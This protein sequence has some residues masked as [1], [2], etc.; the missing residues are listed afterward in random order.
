MEKYYYIASAFSISV[1][2]SIVVIPKILVISAM[3]NLYDIPDARKIHHDAISR[4]GGVAFLPIILFSLALISAIH[5]LINFN[6]LFD[7]QVFSNICMVCCGLIILFLVGIADDLIGLRYKSKFIAQILCGAL[8]VC[9]GVYINNL[10]GFLGI[11]EI[12]AIIGMPFTIFL[13][14]YIINAINLIDGVDGL[15][16]GLSSIALLGFG[17]HFATLNLW[18]YTAFCAVTLGVLVPFF[19]F[20]VFGDAKRG[21]KIFM[22]DTGSLTIG[23]I[24]SVLAIRFSMHNEIATSQHAIGLAFSLVL[25]PLLDVVRVFFHR[26]RMHKHPFKPDRNHIHHKFIDSGLSSRQT[27]IC[28]LSIALFVIIGNSILLI[29]NNLDINI[30]LII[31][32]GFYAMLNLWLAYRIKQRGRQSAKISVPQKIEL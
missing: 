4:L 32:L 9:S 21:R 19:F 5:N 22:G 13:V 27:M 16:S 20:N 8:L 6:H 14:V 10:Y 30:V 7:N 29:G 28:I 11:Y 23:F 26:I 1:L 24:L 25:I 17:I 18:I 15:A 3:K 12:P 2:L 31:D